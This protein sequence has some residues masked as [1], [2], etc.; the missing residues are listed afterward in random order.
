MVLVGRKLRVP[1]VLL[2]KV[3]TGELQVVAGPANVPVELS[4][5]VGR[6]TRSKQ[7]S[8]LTERNPG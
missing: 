7:L 8:P 3:L 1:K 4:D 6:R 5:R 2:V